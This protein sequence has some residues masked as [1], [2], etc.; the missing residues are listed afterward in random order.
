MNGFINTRHEIAITQVLDIP[1]KGGT[2]RNE[3]IN[4]LYPNG[5][6]HVKC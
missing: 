1:K 4:K 6:L 5:I 3:F 2:I